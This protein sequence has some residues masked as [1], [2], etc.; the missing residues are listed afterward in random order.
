MYQRAVTNAFG[1]G[2]LVEVDTDSIRAVARVR[3]SSGAGRI[4]IA[5]E[6]GQY[7]PWVDADVRIRHFGNDATRSRL[8]KI[9]HSGATTALLQLTGA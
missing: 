6:M 8:A 9:I 4:H 5:F 2:D 3:E 7:L 1:V